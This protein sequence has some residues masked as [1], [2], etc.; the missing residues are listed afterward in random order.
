MPRTL[1][2]PSTSQFA[3]FA[4]RG[5]L[6]VADLQ[7][8]RAVSKEMRQAARHAPSGRCVSWGIPF[9]IGRPA[10]LKR[11]M[12]KMKL[13]PTRAQWL[14]FVHTSDAR[15]QQRD[16]SGFPLEK[17]GTGRLAEHAAT[18]IV[19]YADGTEERIPIRRRHEIGAFQRIWGENC[20]E[21]VAHAK[22]RPTRAH[23]E[24][25]HW[26]WGGSQTRVNAGDGGPWVN[27]LYAWEN[28]HPRKQIVGLRLE[29]ASGVV[30]LSAVS[31]GKS[32]SHPLCWQTRQKAVLRLPRG[33]KFDPSMNETG[34]LQQIQLDMG[35]VIS[36][37]PRALYPNRE[38]SR[39]YNNRLPEVS[40]REVLVEYTA[41]PDASFHLSGGKTVSL[42]RP[43]G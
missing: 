18:Y 11:D 41:H 14:V 13:V 12:L 27:W 7:T 24:Q 6:K 26:N 21:A 2:G 36:A 31:A 15:P 4:L 42:R 1:D 40:E 33:E 37:Y 20:F 5:N 43:S 25:T 22:P 17:T 30:L 29:P 9:R 34:L 28:P 19:V 10:L 23:H 35:Q 38:W 16:G 3:P 39:T 8:S 32:S